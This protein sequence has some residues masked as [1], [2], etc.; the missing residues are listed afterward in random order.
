MIKKALQVKDHEKNYHMNMKLKS[1]MEQHTI[2]LDYLFQESCLFGWYQ[3]DHNSMIGGQLLPIS[4]NC[5]TIHLVY[6]NIYFMLVSSQEFLSF[7]TSS[8]DPWNEYLLT[9]RL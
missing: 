6:T 4:A 5:C 2:V 3:N 1:N 8:D 9:R 7:T